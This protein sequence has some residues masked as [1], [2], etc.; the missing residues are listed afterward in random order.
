METTYT[1]SGSAF[2]CMVKITGAEPQETY[3]DVIVGLGLLEQTI[4]EI[5]LFVCAVSVDP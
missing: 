5:D 1:V 4:I 2:L 3:E